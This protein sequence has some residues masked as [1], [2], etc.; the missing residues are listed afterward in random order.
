MVASL[1]LSEWLVHFSTESI[2]LL[3]QSKIEWPIFRRWEKSPHAAVN[4]QN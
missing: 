3:L 1:K 4:K 2:N